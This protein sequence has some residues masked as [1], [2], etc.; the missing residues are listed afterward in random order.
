[1]SKNENNFTSSF[2]EKNFQFF[3][4]NLTKKIQTN[5]KYQEFFR[6]LSICHTS[7]IEKSDVIDE[8]RY[9]AESP[10]E[11][12]LVSAARNFGFVFKS[13]TYNT[14]TINEMGSYLIQQN[15]SIPIYKDFTGS[16]VTYKII[17][18]LQFN[19]D[20]KRMS[21]LVKT[22]KGDANLL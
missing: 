13:R 14:I 9:R 16:D 11:S 17:A 4:S 6:A 8:L 1:M 5:S 20:R 10:D 2:A 3:D 22:P 15:S 7:V 21:L 19:S 18:V 12:A